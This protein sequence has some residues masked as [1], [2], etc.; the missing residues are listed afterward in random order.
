MCYN[1]DPNHGHTGAW[2]GFA[3]IENE[4]YAEAIAV[5]EKSLQT[6]PTLQRSLTIA[7]AYAK[8]GQRQKAEEMMARLREIAKT[9]Y[10]SNYFIAE[11]Y[12]ALGDR[13]KAFA[14]LEQ[15]FQERDTQLTRLKVDPHFAPLRDDPRY[16]GL[17]KRMNL[18]E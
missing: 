1:L 9:R 7:V 12:I 15:A 5:S 10:V 14:E 2:L 18:P 13:D 4:M 6:N 11:I 16:A 3:Y 8:T 17:L